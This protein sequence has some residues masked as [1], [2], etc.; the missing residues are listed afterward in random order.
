MTL[1]D[2]IQ[3]L[4]PARFEVLPEHCIT[5]REKVALNQESLILMNVLGSELNATQRFPM[6]SQAMVALLRIAVL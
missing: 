2:V 4:G 6:S 1:T 5:S 3:S